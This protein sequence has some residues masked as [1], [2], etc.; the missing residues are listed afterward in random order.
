M[1]FIVNSGI[2]GTAMIIF[3]SGMLLLLSWTAINI[4]KRQDLDGTAK[5]LWAV[6]IVVRGLLGIVLYWVMKPR[7]RTINTNRT[8]TD[9]I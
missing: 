7:K 3:A 6:A 1:D 8:T 4:S 5:A 9:A 2:I